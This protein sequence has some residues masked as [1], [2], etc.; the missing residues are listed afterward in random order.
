M[1]ARGSTSTFCFSIRFFIIHCTA[2]Y[3]ATYAPVIAAHLVPPS[4]R[5]ASQS[6]VIVRSPIFSISK[7]ERS[8]RPIR[9]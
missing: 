2:S 4:A 5:K 1:A 7:T 3:A 8:D 9:R 6:I